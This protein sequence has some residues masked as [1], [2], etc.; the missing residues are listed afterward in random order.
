MALKVQE[1][2]AL[3]KE[4]ESLLK[5]LGRA[6]KRAETYYQKWKELSDEK[7]EYEAKIHDQVMAIA[8]AYE[9]RLA[10]M[11][12]MF[13]DG[14]LNES[15]VKDWLKDKEFALVKNEYGFEVVFK[16]NEDESD[17]IQDGKD[18]TQQE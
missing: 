5:K 3:R 4:V 10:Y 13:S 11:M 18:E 17:N 6:N 8:S 14:T 7:Q 9:A 12:D 1:N 2:K 16:E 15:D